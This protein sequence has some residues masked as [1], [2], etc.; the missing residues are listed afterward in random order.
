MDDKKKSLYISLSVY[1]WMMV[2]S[3]PIIIGGV[4]YYIAL[5]CGFLSSR[6]WW[7]CGD[8]LI[9]IDPNRLIRIL[10]GSPLQKRCCIIMGRSF[11]I[12]ILFTACPLVHS[13]FGYNVDVE[14][15]KDIQ[16]YFEKEGRGRRTEKARR[17]FKGNRKFKITFVHDST[18]VT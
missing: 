4:L 3:A 14:F 17:G 13:L 5:M 16:T 9:D 1:Y 7:G 11:Y 6:W 15:A 8:A 18:K 2:C 12:L 10:T